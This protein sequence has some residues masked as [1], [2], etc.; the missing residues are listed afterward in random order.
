[1]HCW[2]TYQAYEPI[3]HFGKW[4]ACTCGHSIFQNALHSFFWFF[5][6]VIPNGYLPDTHQVS[7][8]LENKKHCC[9]HHV[10]PSA[11]GIIS[12][13]PASPLPHRGPYSGNAY[14]THNVEGTT[15]KFIISCS[16]FCISLLIKF[17]TQ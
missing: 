17:P 1:V 7:G 9:L 5:F 16:C 11:M 2:N 12:I 6:P 4:N 3:V 10:M 8:E 15:L 13:R 14:P